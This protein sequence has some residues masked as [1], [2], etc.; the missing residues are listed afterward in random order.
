MAVDQ[1]IAPKFFVVNFSIK[2][3]L[4]VSD[5]QYTDLLIAMGHRLFEAADERG[6]LDL[7]LLKELDR[8]AE[9]RALTRVSTDAAEAKVKLGIKAWFAEVSG[10]LRTGFEQK[11][12]FRRTF[13]PQVP[14]LIE[15]LNRIIRAVET[16]E[17]C[18]R[19]EVLLIVDDLD[20]PDV[21]VVTDLFYRK[22][23]IITQPQCKIVFTVPTALLYSSDFHLAKGNFAKSFLLPNVKITS[24]DGGKD[25]QHW[26]TMEE[27][28]R[29][30]LDRRLID[31]DALQLA[32]K[33]SGGVVRE[34]IR[35]M[36]GA[37]GK[38]LAAKKNSIALAHVEK[39]VGDLRADY[40]RSLTREE[41]VVILRQV[42]KTKAL[43]YKDEKPLLRLLHTLFILS[44]PNSPCW[45]DVNPVVLPLIAEADTA[46]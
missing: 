29:R 13:E 2:D 25:S 14:R 8:W 6:A 32:V 7:S 31:D 23:P 4:N 34:L 10:M 3:A 33:M 28:V 46:A 39:E 42:A 20:K 27:V 11:E 41:D 45:Y 36:Q 9:E 44:Y 30:R 19:R 43:L 15:F 26:K 24:K 37:C 12:E 16:S 17:A 40:S 18:G 35:L 22:G 38:A 5:L 21:E 1:E